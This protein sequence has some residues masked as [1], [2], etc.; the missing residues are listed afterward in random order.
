MFARIGTPNKVN[1]DWILKEGEYISADEIEIEKGFLFQGNKVT[2]DKSVVSFMIPGFAQKEEPEYLGKIPEDMF[3]PLL[4][5]EGNLTYAKFEATQSP[6][7]KFLTIRPSAY[8]SKS[9][10]GE[11]NDYMMYAITGIIGVVQTYENG[12]SHVYVDKTYAGISPGDLIVPFK[13]MMANV[14]FSLNKKPK[15]VDTRVVGIQDGPFLMAGTYQFVHLEK[16]EGINVGDDV[17]IHMN[18]GGLVFF[19]E[20]MD[21]PSVRTARARIVDIGTESMAAVLLNS[22]AEV[23]VGATTKMEKNQLSGPMTSGIWISGKQPVDAATITTR[24]TP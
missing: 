20:T 7:K 18:Q 5:N 16:K 11:S 21:F 2:G 6:G 8:H 14:D 4:S 17:L 24:L 22:N 23:T 19:E 9:P 10:T 13:N 12:F 15:N 1:K 3:V